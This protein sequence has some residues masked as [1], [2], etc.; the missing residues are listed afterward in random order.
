M[1]SQTAIYELNFNSII[2]Y[3]VVLYAL[4]LT[5]NKYYFYNKKCSF[6]KNVGFA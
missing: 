6:F 1:F 3:V 4:I 2:A 5:H